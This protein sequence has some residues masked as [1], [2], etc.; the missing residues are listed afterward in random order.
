M[1]TYV[2]PLTH[3]PWQVH[4]ETIT[5]PREAGL[6]LK[7]RIKARGLRIKD[8]AIRISADP[9]YMSHLL[10]GRVNIVESDYFPMLAEELDLT[11]EEI[12][13]LKPSA[14]ITPPDPILEPP[15]AREADPFDYIYVTPRALAHA[16]PGDSLET[17]P[18]GRTTIVKKL[19]V[20]RRHTEYAYAEGNSMVR[21]DGTGIHDG[22]LLFIDVN[23][24]ELRDGETYLIKVPGNG[25]YVKRARWMLD[26]WW[27]HSDNPDYPPYKEDKAQVVGYVY[28]AQNPTFKP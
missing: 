5:D 17:I 15:S 24:L 27:L 11:V 25:F 2:T 13:A 21:R 3:R 28:L 22:A 26:E 1:M 14:F 16:G 19:D 10:S 23:D 9:S 7:K 20:K 8:V 4:M 12:R 6:F 18:R